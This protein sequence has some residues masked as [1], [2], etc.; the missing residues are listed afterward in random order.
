MV[1]WKAFW[2]LAGV[3]ILMVVCGWLIDDASLALIVIFLAAILIPP[4]RLL[5]IS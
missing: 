3:Y 5:F 1:S 2:I 4:I